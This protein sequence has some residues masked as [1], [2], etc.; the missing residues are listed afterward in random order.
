MFDRARK[1]NYSKV[2]LDTSITNTLAQRFYFKVGM[3]PM[4]FH[5]SCEMNVE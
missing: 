4:A 1:N 2:I 3:F 5:F